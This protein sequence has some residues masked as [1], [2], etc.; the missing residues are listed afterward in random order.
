MCIIT[1]PVGFLV[2]QAF[3]SASFAKITTIIRIRFNKK[4]LASINF[5]ESRKKSNVL[6][7]FKTNFKVKHIFEQKWLFF[8]PCHLHLSIKVLFSS[9]E[10]LVSKY[11]FA[12][13]FRDFLCPKFSKTLSRKRPKVEKISK[14]SA[15]QSCM[16]YVSKLQ[17][18][19]LKITKTIWVKFKFSF[20][21]RD[22]SLCQNSSRK[23][24]SESFSIWNKQSK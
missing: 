2:I 5:L 8:S 14:L 4:F 24:E 6:K 7:G 13:M 21:K 10:R 18:F 3:T 1:T 12:T 23:S 15:R 11:N 22:H 19:K 20:S 9:F 17:K 16:F